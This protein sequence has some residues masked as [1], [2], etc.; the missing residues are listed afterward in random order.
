MM[1]GAKTAAPAAEIAVFKNRRRGCCFA[2]F[3]MTKLLIWMV[4][5]IDEQSP[6]HGDMF[7]GI[8][9]HSRTTPANPH[10]KR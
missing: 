8:R 6:G 4:G 9:Q 7:L 2:F 1:V 3:D 10:T 5:V